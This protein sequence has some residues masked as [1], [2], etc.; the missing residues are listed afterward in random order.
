MKIDVTWLA[1]S[2]WVIPL[3]LAWHQAS[4]NLIMIVW[5][6]P[7]RNHVKCPVPWHCSLEPAARAWCVLS[8]E[9]VWADGHALFHFHISFHAAGYVYV[10]MHVYT[11]F[12]K[13]SSVAFPRCSIE[14][15]SSLGLSGTG[16]MV[17]CSRKQPLLTEFLPWG[18]RSFVG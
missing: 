10:C 6:S 2:V 18:A 7:Q 4:L 1:H 12:L 14:S 3:P 8:K 5:N 11:I 9:R 16:S 13:E 17:I 15:V